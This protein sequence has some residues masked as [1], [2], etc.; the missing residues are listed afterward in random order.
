[1]RAYLFNMKNACLYFVIAISFFSCRKE[2]PHSDVSGQCH[3]FGLVEIPSPSYFVSSGP[4]YSK[5]AFNPNDPN[6]FVYQYKNGSEAELRIFNIATQEQRTLMASVNLISKPTWSTQGKIAFD[7]ASNYQIWLIDENGDSLTQHTD[8]TSNL[9]PAWNPEGTKVFYTYS[10]DLGYPYFLL[11]HNHGAGEPDTVLYDY[12]GY[13]VISPSGVIASRISHGSSI[14]VGVGNISVDSNLEYSVLVDIYEQSL[15]SL[16]S[17]S[18]SSDGNSVYLTC[19]ANSEKDGLYVVDV[20]SGSL[21]KLKEHCFFDIIQSADCSPDGQHLIIERKSQ[22][23]E[24]T[25]K[26]QFTGK[27]LVQSRLYLLNLQTG[28]EELIEIE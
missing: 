14:Q 25:D 26:G 3:S 4:Q 23:M 5:P 21:E 11:S 7:D 9:H 19:I 27:I 2:K 15:G 8:N 12:A 18:I 1:M 17:L 16:T 24:Y 28:E 13:N 10:P 20:N 22:K 6:E